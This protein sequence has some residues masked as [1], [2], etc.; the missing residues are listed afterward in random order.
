MKSWQEEQLQALLT[1]ENEQQLFEEL[2]KIGKELG[3]DF[4]TYGLRTPLPV[5]RPKVV[6]FSNYPDEWQKRYSEKNYIEIDPT[7]THGIHSLE[8]LVWPND[9]LSSS[10]EFWEEA[11][12]FGLSVGWAQASRDIYGVGGGLCV[13]R[14]ADPISEEELREISPKLTWLTQVAH[15]GMSKCLT[16]KLMP[17]TET[18]L[19]AREIS[20]L[21]WTA[22]GKTAGEISEILGISERT[23]NY[24]INNAVEKLG[25]TNKLAAAVRATVLGI[26]S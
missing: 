12:S 26:L 9:N 6:M 19:T 3:F 2:A 8:P 18:K 7:V 11:R 13:A 23:V 20:V 16:S 10:E 5:S 1:A 14:S 15:Q 4:C 17:E 22:D 21:R 24:H 25:T